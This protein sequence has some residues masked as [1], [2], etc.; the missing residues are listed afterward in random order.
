MF[1]YQNKVEVANSVFIIFVSSD[2]HELIIDIKWQWLHLSNHKISK[3]IFWFV[4]FRN[5]L[6]RYWYINLKSVLF[7]ANAICLNYTYF[8]LFN[9]FVI[10]NKCFTFE[11][12]YH[13]IIWQ[14]NFTI[15]LI[16]NILNDFVPSMSMVYICICF[17]LFNV[18]RE[19]LIVRVLK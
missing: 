9:I 15:F 10:N 4:A 12:K 17:K 7:I 16:C 2:N 19:Y 14:E 18:K 13:F 3:D 8:S 5:W 1:I 6:S 11:C